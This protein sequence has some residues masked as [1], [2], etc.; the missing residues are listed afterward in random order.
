MNNIIEEVTVE[1]KK[2]LLNKNTYFTDKEIIN[3]IPLDQIDTNVNQFRSFIKL[4]PKDLLERFE[5]EES[6]IKFLK[7]LYLNCYSN[8]IQIFSK[9]QNNSVF[10]KTKEELGTDFD[11]TKLFESL[12]FFQTLNIQQL[13]DEVSNSFSE[14][15]CLSMNTEVPTIVTPLQTQIIKANLSLNCRIHILDFKLR[16][17]NLTSIFDN[18]EF[19]T[20][21][22]T[23][24]NYLFSLYV[25]RVK[26]AS[27]SFYQSLIEIITEELSS[28]LEDGIEYIDPI[29]NKII[30]F[31]LPITEDNKEQNFLKYLKYI[32]DEEFKISSNNLN[33]FFKL[34][35]R[36]NDVTINLSNL[37]TVKDYLISNLQTVGKN[38][39]SEIN[40]SNLFYYVDVE[41]Q[42]DNSIVTLNLAIKS[43]ITSFDPL[44]FNLIKS[45][46]F[47]INNPS[48]T[49]NDVTDQQILEAK[50]QI[51]NSTDFN[52]L[53]EYIFPLQK[54]LNFSSILTILL[55]SNY[56]SNL[57][58]SFDGA[59]KACIN[60]H[61]GATNGTEKDQCEQVENSSSFGFDLEIAKIIAQTPIA[62]IKSIEETYDP[63][64]VIASKI[65]K[66]AEL[67]GAPDLSII[68]YSAMLM[69]PPPF[70]PAIPIV[71]PLG[72][73]YWGISAAETVTNTAK[74]NNGINVDFD[75][76]ASIEPKNPFKSSC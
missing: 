37:Y 74:G 16:K 71:P 8:L 7:K 69:A 62:I 65:K 3:T 50:Q 33:L 22:D 68:P 29:T 64:I 9:S 66:A 44:Y 76:S 13:K 17:I 4:I 26:K 25:E 49:I 19:F 54:I 5:N 72:L 42:T 45:S 47:I 1:N 32:F 21:D 24:V 70:G 12:N 41:N 11:G 20:K 63:N 67:V 39:L 60:I 15:P 2:V 36:K 55:S 73:I 48:A 35:I 6:K 46:K 31:N 57:N 58:S 61:N 56:Y 28:N 18:T 23:L 34:K 43:G 59:F 40:S 52:L 51:N 75:W 27:L 38:R 30:E 14:N 10:L 53:F